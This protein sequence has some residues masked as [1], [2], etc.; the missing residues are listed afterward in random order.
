MRRL[1]IVPSLLAL[2]LA[3]DLVPAPG[4]S[5]GL[6]P[7]ALAPAASVA[8]APAAAGAAPVLIGTFQPDVSGSACAAWDAGCGRTA[9]RPTATEGV[10]SLTLTVPAGD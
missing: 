9:L 4:T 2:L 1:L 7:A 6:A 8:A 10:W 5:A 3:G